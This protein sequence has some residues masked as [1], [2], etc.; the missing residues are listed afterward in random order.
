MARGGR[1]GLFQEDNELG[2]EIAGMCL[3]YQMEVPKDVLFDY[4]ECSFFHKKLKTLTPFAHWKYVIERQGMGEA[5]KKAR[6]ALAFSLLSV[7][8]SLFSLIKSLL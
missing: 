7:A 8:M 3:W 5:Y 1:C 6:R 2:D 4:R